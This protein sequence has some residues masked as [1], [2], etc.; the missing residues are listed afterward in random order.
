LEVVEDDD[1]PDETEVVF[2][3]EAAA[4]VDREA[5]VAFTAGDAPVSA[6][7]RSLANGSVWLAP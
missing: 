5:E 3:V 7:V 1:P 4:V 2:E 6:P